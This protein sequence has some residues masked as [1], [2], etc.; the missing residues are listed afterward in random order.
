MHTH[1]HTHTPTRA[2]VH[3]HTHANSHTPLRVEKL[4]YPVH[5]FD[6]RLPGVTSMS[7]DIHKYGLG[8]KVT[9]LVVSVISSKSKS[10][11]I[12]I[13]QYHSHVDCVALFPG[14]VWYSSACA[15]SQIQEVEE[16]GRSGIIHHLK[17]QRD[18][19]GTHSQFSGSWFSS[20]SIEHSTVSSYTRNY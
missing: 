8:A 5:V 2:H 18:W 17:K 10:C 9:V 13:T 11:S 4:G 1:T 15:D 20:S 3:P 6:F 16:W 7:A 19:G 14:L 12:G